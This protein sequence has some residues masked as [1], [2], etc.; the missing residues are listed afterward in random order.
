MPEDYDEEDDEMDYEEDPGPSEDMAGQMMEEMGEEDYEGDDGSGYGAG[1]MMGSGEGGQGGSGTRPPKGPGEADKMSIQKFEEVAAG[2]PNLPYELARQLWGQQLGAT[3]AA[4]MDTLTS[5]EEGAQLLMLAG[6]IPTDAMRAQLLKTLQAHWVD[7]PEAFASAS[8]S[9]ETGIS[10]PGFIAIIK[11]LPRREPPAR[12]NADPTEEMSA[13]YAWMMTA[14]G[15]VR[16]FCERF[17]TAADNEMVNTAEVLETLPFPAHSPDSLTHVYAIDWQKRVGNRVTGVSVDP[18]RVY[19]LRF[20]ETAQYTKVLG[21][22]KRAVPSGTERPVKNGLLWIDGDKSGPEPG[23]RT[24]MDVIIDRTDFNAE[25][26]RSE[27]E[28]MV[29]QILYVEINDPN[30]ETVASN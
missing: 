21:A 9:A 1:G 11:S 16:G 7:G 8:V 10:D 19:Y 24:S 4:K 12:A 3:M 29:I 22:Y 14:Y 25:R 2:N 18:M 17:Q 20:E 30:P 6:H 26:N 27:A 15:T 28:P 23:R 13:Q 5:L